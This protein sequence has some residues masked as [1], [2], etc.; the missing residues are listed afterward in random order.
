MVSE[1]ALF[2]DVDGTLLE[3]QANPEDVRSTAELNQLLQDLRDRFGGALAL[4]SGRPIA[5]LDRIFSPL[6]F[7]AA[8]EHGVELRLPT[9][10]RVTCEDPLPDTVRERLRCYVAK[11][12]GLLLEMKS[13]GASL[14]YRQV[15]D[16]ER[17]CRSFMRNVA[18]DPASGHRLIDGKKVLELIPAAANKGRA[19]RELLCHPPFAGRSPIFVG[20]DVT[21]EDGFRVVNELGGVSVL[22]TR[23]RPT[24]A[25]YCLAGV[26][27]LHDWLHQVAARESTEGKAIVQS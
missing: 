16:L 21:D 12:D 9:G 22:I 15:P 2:L 23:R 17:A 3:L 4:V 5:A 27:E 20:D 10:D 11:N 19:I 8:G 24:A 25:V 7:A 26:P 6:E 1:T 14:H 13:G 18:A